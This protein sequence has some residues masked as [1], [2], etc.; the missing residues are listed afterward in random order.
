MRCEVTII[1]E[2][3]GQKWFRTLEAT[4]TSEAAG[5]AL[6]L[7]EVAAFFAGR[8]FAPMCVHAKPADAEEVRKAA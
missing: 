3:C 5:Q 8:P 2:G 1:A 7:P 4:T 6:R